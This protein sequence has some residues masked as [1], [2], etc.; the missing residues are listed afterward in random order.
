MSGDEGYGR[1]VAAGQERRAGDVEADVEILVEQREQL[2]RALGRVHVPHHEGHHRDRAVLVRGDEHAGAADLDREATRGVGRAVGAE[3]VPQGLGDRPREIL[4]R[5]GVIRL[6]RVQRLL[7]AVRVLRR[8]VL[9]VQLVLVGGGGEEGRVGDA[10]DRLQRL[11]GPV[12]GRVDVRVDQVEVGYRRLVGRRRRRHPADPQQLADLTRGQPEPV[13]EHLVAGHLRQ[14]QRG[15]VR[16]EELEVGTGHVEGGLEDRQAGEGAGLEITQLPGQVCA[17]GLPRGG[18][19]VVG[20][21]L[22][23]HGPRVGQ[24]TDIDGAHRSAPAP[25]NPERDG[26]RSGHLG[27][28]PESCPPPPPTVTRP[29]R[30][31]WTCSATNS[32]TTA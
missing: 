5:G 6:V 24:G 25:P 13:G 32:P 19:G 11:P 21:L 22:P 3:V 23:G 14:D 10:E 16:L 31:S 20:A 17:E 18:D 9:P 7:P 15:V 12:D 1:D 4:R 30:G 28:C 2:R 27:P 29:R 26:V 8:P